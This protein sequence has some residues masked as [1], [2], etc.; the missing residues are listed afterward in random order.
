ML[1][2]YKL[3]SAKVSAEIEAQE[4]EDQASISVIAGR[5]TATSNFKSKDSVKVKM[6][7]SKG[8]GDLEV[9]VESLK[10]VVDKLKTENEALK[11]ENGKI[12][13]Q[14][15]K[16]ISEKALRQKINNLEQLV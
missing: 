10:R 6:S 14:T 9:V 5:T 4:A 12:Q 8:T 16:I 2:Q 7:S 1:E 15:G 13:G 3:S 11:R